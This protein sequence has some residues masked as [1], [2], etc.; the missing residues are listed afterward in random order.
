MHKNYHV[1]DN[2]FYFKESLPLELC[3]SVIDLALTNPFK[4]EDEVNAAERDLSRMACSA[5]VVHQVRILIL[6]I[7]K[8]SFIFYI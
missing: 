4:N 8:S 6:S 7:E 1:K 3:Q 5:S 2:S